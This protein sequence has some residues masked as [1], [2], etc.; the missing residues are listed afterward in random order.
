[1]DD[2]NK[3]LILATVLSFFV[4]LGWFVVGPVLFPNWFP[5]EPATAPL[6]AL[7]AD[8][9]APAPATEAT[10]TATALDAA[11]QAEAP[12]LTLDTPKLQGSISTLG[13]R[14]DD[15]SLK[16]YRQ[17]V[18]PGSPNVKLLTPVGTGPAYYAVFGFQPGQGMTAAD[19]PGYD[20]EWQA[21]SGTLAPDN[22]VTMTWTN[23]KGLNFTRTIAVDASYMFTVTDKVDNTGTATA[24]LAPIGVIARHGLPKLENIYVV[25]E[26]LI[27]RTDGI[28]HE[29]KYSGIT[30][31]ADFEGAKGEK[32]DATTDG[33]IGFTDHYWMTTLVPEQG[34]PFS[35]IT[36]YTPGNDIYQVEVRQPT[37]SIAPGASASSSIQLF[38]GAKEWE[39]IHTYQNQPSWYE[40]VLGDRTDTSRPQ[41]AGFIDSIDWGWFFFLTKPIFCCAALVARPDR[42][43]GS[44]HHRADLHPETAG[45]SAGLQIQR[46]D[47]PDEGTAAR[48]GGAEGKGAATTSKSCSAT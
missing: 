29:S 10:G 34:K 24:S 8:G 44:G 30:G 12:R 47:G 45:L 28:L 14:F 6:T 16:T 13:G 39:A 18:A 40:W 23:G 33:W 5:A 4:I 20:T 48:D 11:P 32:I 22:P 42:Q 3:N 37:M 35:A 25:H 2:Q 7:P 38:A 19:V 17:T 43:H 9:T 1:M 27:R 46:L 26:G 41:I 36:K 31:L 21:V 15:L